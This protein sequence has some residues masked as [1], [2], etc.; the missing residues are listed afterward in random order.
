MAAD[1]GP[2]EHGQSGVARAHGRRGLGAGQHGCGRRHVLFGHDPP[3][4][5]GG[6]CRV[7]GPP[8]RW[9]SSTSTRWRSAAT[10]NEQERAN[11]AVGQ[12]A[13][14][15]V[16]A[17]PG[18]APTARVSAVAGLGR[19]DSRS[20]PAP[21]VRRHARVGRCGCPPEPGTTVRVL[22]Q[23]GTVD[24]VLLMPRQALFEIG[25]K[26][27][28]Y[29]RTG[30]GDVFVP[31]PDQSAAPDR[32]PGGRRRRR[33]GLRGRAGRSGCGAE[34]RRR[35]VARVEPAWIPGK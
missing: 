12:T 14:I 32:E 3:A 4:V 18:L 19:A 25:G 22:V 33:R 1:P 8:P 11:V 5:P 29:L 15:E 23:G 34:A 26:P 9:M 6:R 13:R 28:V 17:V 24:N 2:A 10:V 16:D 31:A 21:A 7:L 20:G 27:T 30:S 35:G